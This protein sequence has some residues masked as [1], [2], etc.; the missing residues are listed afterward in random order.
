MTFIIVITLI[1]VR[2]KTPHVLSYENHLFSLVYFLIRVE[3][4]GKI[5][6]ELLEI[7]G[8]SLLESLLENYQAFAFLTKYKLKVTLKIIRRNR[9]TSKKSRHAHR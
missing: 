1:I 5:K 9:F 8:D 6:L 2:I 3:P 7:L 4:L